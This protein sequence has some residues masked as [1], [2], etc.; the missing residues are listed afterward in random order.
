MRLCGTAIDNMS[1][2]SAAEKF[3][4][5]LDPTPKFLDPEDVDDGMSLTD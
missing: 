2:K 3:A 1:K 5:L 4:D